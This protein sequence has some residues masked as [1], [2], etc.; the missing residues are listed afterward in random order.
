MHAVTYPTESA[1]DTMP[2]TNDTAAWSSSLLEY[3]LLA[4]IMGSK[5]KYIW[6]G[7]APIVRAMQPALGFFHACI[8]GREF[9][10]QAGVIYSYIVLP[11]HPYPKIAPTLLNRCISFPVIKPLNT[12]LG[13]LIAT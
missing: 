2:A 7:P 9:H 5:L 13:T 6:I 8:L 10:A 1:D 11:M 4:N 12:L 3:L